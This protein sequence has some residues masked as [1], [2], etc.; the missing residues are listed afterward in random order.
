MTIDHITTEVESLRAEAQREHAFYTRT[1][2]DID[3]DPTLS[4]AG[5]DAQKQD[6]R[7]A[8]R[9][10]L[11]DIRRKEEAILEREIS[12]AL[13]RIEAPTRPGNTDIIAYRDAQD[14]ADRI[15]DPDEANRL[16]ERS[17]RQGDDSLAHAIFRAAVDRGYQTV[18]TTFTTAKPALAT[19]VADLQTLEGAKKNSFERTVAYGLL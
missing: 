11:A 2:N 14:R 3:N 9:A 7:E 8:T 6:F 18:I 15:D 5:R 1:V 12:N 10:R 4:P 16:L 19:A 17:L 13:S